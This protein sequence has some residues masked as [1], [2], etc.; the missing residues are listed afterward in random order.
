MGNIESLD[1]A[2]A[3]LQPHQ[4][5]ERTVRE[6]Q[7]KHAAH[8]LGSDPASIKQTLTKLS[9]LQRDSENCPVSPSAAAEAV[10]QLAAAEPAKVA[11]SSGQQ[12]HV[13]ATP[14]PS[15]IASVTTPA[16]ILRAA[17]RGAKPQHQQG[18]GARQQLSARSMC[19]PRVPA[20][21]AEPLKRHPT[22]QD[23][24]QNKISGSTPPSEMSIAAAAAEAV[25][26][27]PAAGRRAA[28]SRKESRRLTF[29][30]PSARSRAIEGTDDLVGFHS[31]SIGMPPATLKR[32][33]RKRRVQCLLD[34]SN[35]LVT[36]K[37][38]TAITSFD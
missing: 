25:P 35:P 13:P 6:N 19:P 21:A 11:L 5:L 18:A 38:L 30:T 12:P 31:A 7:S 20:S 2:S 26:V 22:Q 4:N 37:Q 1:A 17:M 24:Q 14:Q 33:L 9:S 34:A 32:N 3:S 23:L 10:P 27:T 15:Q 29:E 8:G 28:S 36:G 16:E